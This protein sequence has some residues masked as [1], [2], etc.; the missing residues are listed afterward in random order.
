MRNLKKKKIKMNDAIRVRINKTMRT[1]IKLWA[2][3]YRISESQFVRDALACYIFGRE[4]YD[5][6]RID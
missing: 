5:G 4:A 3:G 6:K 2:K 1:M